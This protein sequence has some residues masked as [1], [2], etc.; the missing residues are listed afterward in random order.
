MKCFHL[1]AVVAIVR[2]KNTAAPF[3][4]EQSLMDIA[5]KNY[6]LFTLISMQDNTNTW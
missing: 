4:I 3:S 1:T 6:D 2:V 5:K